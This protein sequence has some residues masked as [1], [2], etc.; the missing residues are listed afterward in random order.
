MTAR[1]SF[2]AVALGLVALA[3]L[4]AVDRTTTLTAA[5]DVLRVRAGRYADLF[6]NA[7]KAKA[8]NSILALETV[9]GGKLAERIVVPSTDGEELESAPYVLYQDALDT[10]FVLWQ[11]TLNGAYSQFFLASV[12]A[13]RWS[14]PISLTTELWSTQTP[15]EITVTSDTYVEIDAAGHSATHRRTV[16]HTVWWEDTEAERHTV[17]SPV[18]LIDG[19][20]VG[21][22]PQIVLD[23]LD[24]SGDVATS[25]LQPSLYRAPALA[26][27]SRPHSVVASFARPESGRLLNVEIEVLP[28]Q[29]SQLAASL[30]LELSGL[31]GQGTTPQSLADKARAH[32]LIAGAK[33]FNPRFLESLANETYGHILVAAGSTP[34][35]ITALPGEARAHVLIAGSELSGHSLLSDAA[36]RTIEMRLDADDADPTLTFQ[37]RALANLPAPETAAGPTRILAAGSGDGALVAWESQADRIAYREGDS[38]SWSDVKTVTLGPQLDREHAYEMLERR[39][40]GL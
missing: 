33:W 35:G 40:R 20:Y 3:P 22:N 26:P 2:L 27:G 25:A 1:L 8:D 19:V 24:L 12:S 32:I 31:V 4:G 5:G 7:P 30:R 29:L 36:R 6:P 21:W 9:R 11:R 16:V 37:V 15:P 23:D 28:W 34:G 10:A 39:A 17:Y 14:T 38:T 18:V 13:G